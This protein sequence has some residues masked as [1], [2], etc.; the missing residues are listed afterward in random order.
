MLPTASPCPHPAISGYSIIEQLYVGSRTIVYRA[1][2]QS[3]QR[4]VII[5]LLQQDYPSFND[6]FQFR[7]Q[8]TIAKNLEISGI[9]QTYSLE[10]CGNSYALVMEDFGGISLQQFAQEHSLSLPEILAIALQ[11]AEILH[12]LHQVRVIHKDIKPA[13]VLIHP[14][15]KQV[16]LID[17]SIASLL[18]K[19]T[20]EIKNPNRLEG[21]LAYLAPE[22]TGRMNRGI[23]YRADFYALGITLFKL[24]TGQLPFQSDDPM[25]L[26]H[27][28]LA[29]SPPKVDSL[30]PEIPRV[31]SDIVSKLMAKN[32]EDRYQSA[33][34]LQHDLQICLS[35]SNE[36]GHI[37][38]FTIA[39][40]DVC[41]RFLIPEKL[42]GRE[43]EVQTL[44]AAF[45]RV[46]DGNS[47]LMLIAGF[48]GIGKTAIVNEVH[49]PIV[50]QRG[51]FIK[52]KFDQFNRNIPF[53]AFVQ[54]FRNLMGQLLAE[55][56]LQL[57]T[58]KT[59]ILEALG[60]NAQVIIDVIPELEH[61][62]GAQPLTLELSG[63]AAQNRFNLLFQ[64]FIQV[65]TTPEHPLVMFLDDLQWADSA[66]LKLMQ[67]LMGESQ[68][69]Y[70]LLIGAYRDN[71]VF[72]AHP[73]RLTLDEVSK[74]GATVNTIVLKPLS[75]H[76]LNQ[77]VVDTLTCA[78]AV[79]QPLTELVYQKTQGNPFF[80]T[81]FLKALH[82]DRHITWDAQTGHWQCDITQ[83]RS[84]TLT[85]DV[86]QLMVQQLQKLS[87]ETQAVLKLAACMGNQFDLN[88]LAIVS[89]QSQTTTATALW[90]ALQEGLIL[91]TSQT[92]KFF[93]TE[94]QQAD[95]ESAV[96][97]TYRF[98]HDRVQQ[99]AY[100]LVHDRQ[101]QLTHLKIGQRLLR[102]L[103]GHDREEKLF[104]IVN[105]LNLG[106]ALLATAN[107]RHELAQL[108]LIVGQKAKGSTAYRS[109]DSYLKIGLELLSVEHWQIHPE[110]SWSLFMEATEIAYLNGEFERVEELADI[111]L[112]HTPTLL[113][114]LKVHEIRIQSYTA[115]SCQQQAIDIALQLLNQLGIS[116]SEQDQAEIWQ[117]SKTLVNILP[118]IL[119]EESAARSPMTDPHQLA[120][121]RLLSSA[122]NAAYQ[123]NPNLFVLLVLK[124]VLLSFEHGDAPSSA[125]AYADYG[126]TLCG[127]LNEIEQGYQL[128]QLALRVL[129]QSSSQ[130]LE[131]STRY[132]VNAN[133]RHWKEPLKDT[134]EDL[135]QT[136]LRGLETGELSFACLAANLYCCH[137]YLS[138]VFLQT[139]EESFSIY[140]NSIDKLKQGTVSNHQKIFHNAILFLMGRKKFE[141]DL[142]DY[143]RDLDSIASSYLETGDRTANFYF[144]LNQLI[145]Y[146]YFDNAEKA[147]RNAALARHYLN[148]V[149]SKYLAPLF[150]FYESLAQAAACHEAKNFT[151][152][153][154]EIIQ[155]NQSKLRFWA[156]HSPANYLHKFDLVEAEYYHI[157]GQRAEAIAAYDCAIAGARR[158]DYIQEEALASELAAKFYLN[159]GKEK[160]AAIYMQEAYCGYARWGAKAK[161]DDLEN[162]YPNLLRPIF[163]RTAQ[164][165][166]A[167]ETTVAISAPDLSIHASTDLGG[168]SSMSINNTLDFAAIIKASQS[169]SRTIQLNEL[170]HQLTQII[171][172]NSGGDR[173]ALI[174][175]NQAGEWR[176]EAIATPETTELC[177][178]PLNGNAT[179]PVK[180]I[181]Y[182]KNTQEVVRIDNLKTDLPVIDDYLTQQ[183]PKSVLCLPILNQGQLIGIL[184]LS[185]RSTSRVF[186]SD[187]III[188]E[189]LCTQAAISLE[190]SRLY[191]RLQ[192]DAQD[193]ERSL[194][195][196]QFSQT[197]LQ[198]SES[199]NRALIAAM[200]DLLMRVNREGIYLDIA[201]FDHLNVQNINQFFIG[202]SVYD[203]LPADKAEQRMQA[204]QQTLE[205]GKTQVHE[206]QFMMD[207]QVQYEEVRISVCNQD[208]VLI[209]VRDISDRK[210]AEAVIQQKSQELEQALAELQNTQ[211]QMVQGEK[212]V[213]LGNLV[214][215]IAHEIN[216]PISFLN[217]S[218]NHAQNYVKDLLDHLGLYQ[219]HHPSPATPVTDNAGNIDLEFLSE[220][221]PKLL[222][223]MEAA[224]D[225]I[226]D[227]ST[228][229]RTFSRS[230]TDHKITA[231]LHEGIDSTLLILK[232]R[233]KVNEHRPEI[234]VIQDYGEL[235]LVECFPGQ[236]NQVFMNILANSIDMF[237]EMAL[238][239]SVEELKVSPQQITI[240]TAVVVN[241]V[242]IQICDNGKGMTAE[243]KAKVF[244]HLFTTKSVGKGTGLGLAIARQI[245]VEK[246][247]G[248][249]EVQSEVG[250]GTEFLIR[251]PV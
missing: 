248:I 231:N 20:L 111:I 2:E 24:L 102:H 175:P 224:T 57:Q 65:F 126:V 251:L 75:K 40:R 99:A 215:G 163:Q 84:A 229:L 235:P 142:R 45:D 179:L 110:L 46:L 16:K 81:Q 152:A 125:F 206:Q 28:H 10:S 112:R 143:S 207:N 29:Q 119:N 132:I 239:L 27:C 106:K 183:R 67:L 166:S 199:T 92:Y 127:V 190:N 44:L 213:S 6:L 247:N 37:A 135:K 62:I 178:E 188:L 30:D 18:P 120:A 98:L 168:S 22:Q 14:E 245:V 87:A 144:Y 96:N 117:Q 88:T 218:I 11:L 89:E 39:T 233:L 77:L 138:G 156:T 226:K 53:S 155:K 118:Q 34:G 159:W 69:G 153:D 134:L 35:Q 19:E 56:D 54:A 237:D 189:F 104:D 23:D 139:V 219:Q 83:I 33:L 49:K 184:S 55:S 161:T 187:R 86:V 250:Q 236:L 116:F 41:D 209:I 43:A 74:A 103:S 58:W 169:L 222:N 177:S 148:G 137:S 216:N 150:I 108:N 38:P 151:Q 115:Q 241:Q 225:R 185:N 128:G 197:A 26:V 36:T 32:A 200:P 196:L 205:T 121:M 238:A 191:Q 12:D 93:Q 79:A 94:P 42:Y 52:G 172:Q 123:A 194:A 171:L 133:I 193:L 73:L 71:E 1:V 78:I 158:N 212:M 228:S 70:L 203:S 145:L 246:H 91:P 95:S 130:K 204:I 210:A 15:S 181:Q 25:E 17:F 217:G 240:R 129:S 13:N 141:G 63:S 61:I 234:Q 107:E 8:Y 90:K 3:S 51:Y 31:L 198:R 21:T 202:T 124:K 214:A 160:V 100:S 140:K 9:V 48:S 176:I 146:Y 170:F 227:L 59:Q 4:S 147:V 136:Y 195:D 220:D 243:V 47:E 76:R 154:L 68:T 223:S 192:E 221:L 173:C 64:K 131:A 101:K 249:L 208:E 174:L 230:D 186:T 242:Q 122:T 244:D 82:Q 80:A 149:T 113:D 109:A 97:L 162:C 211:L 72:A 66:S 5:K 85:D 180:L 114:Q 7:N 167:I 232:Y 50:R 164:S 157:L 105:H 201:G 165:L 182:V 60:E